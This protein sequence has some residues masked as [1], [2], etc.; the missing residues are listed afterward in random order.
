LRGDG[1]R[2]AEDADF[3]ADGRGSGIEFTAESAEGAEKKTEFW[4]EVPFF[5]LRPC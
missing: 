3:N 4:E 1:K 2:H 5:T